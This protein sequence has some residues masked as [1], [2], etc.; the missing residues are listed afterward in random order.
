MNALILLFLVLAFVANLNPSRK[1][2]G[3]F[4]VDW[5]E[6]LQATRLWLD[7]AMA[8]LNSPGNYSRLTGTLNYLFSDIN[9][10]TIDVIMNE[11]SGNSEYRPVDIRYIP[12]KGTTNLVT[13]DSSG[14]CTK[15]AQRRDKIQSVQPTL[16]AED[17]FTIN[18]SYVR[19]NAE[20]GVK[21]QDRL[22]KEFRDSMRIVRESM[23]AQCLAKL[24]G[25]F[26]ANPAAEVGAGAYYD[27][28]IIIGSSGKID[29]TQFDAIKI[30]QEDNFMVNGPAAVI[31]LG[32][33]RRYM[34]RLSVGNAND[35][36]IDYKLVS[37][38]F[39]MLHYK[40][41]DAPSVLGHVDRT[42]VIYPGM[43]QFFN[44]NLFRGDFA[45]KVSETHIKGTMQDPIFP[46]TY[47]YTL[48]YDDNCSTGNGL[49]GAWIG[50][51]LT[52][53]DVWNVNEDAFGDVYGD[54]NDFNGVLGYKFN[55]S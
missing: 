23:N 37:D 21:L 10:K 31:G 14:T 55:E 24:A 20:N 25:V 7:D 5:T 35:A 40:D 22:N 26:G 3:V 28:P 16:Y 43:T 47:D 53:F 2:L 29:D 44:Y 45:L 19:Q 12:H 13:T 46:I 36:G 42:L 48:K 1:V 32:N 4:Y 6:K 30:H 8:Q 52:Y 49:Q 33:A 38:E 54:L 41:S 50:R 39:G 9:P 17:K 34:N 18:E 51:V 15:V 11:N 27:L